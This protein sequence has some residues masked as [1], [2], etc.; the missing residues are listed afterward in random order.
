MLTLTYSSKIL[1]WSQSNR[2][3]GCHATQRHA[4]VQRIKVQHFSDVSEQCQG[5]HHKLPRDRSAHIVLVVQGLGASAEG[6]WY[7]FELLID[8]YFYRKYAPC[9]HSPLLIPYT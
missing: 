6:G 1:I 7:V 9:H 4:S 3:R 8:A 5:L 2:L